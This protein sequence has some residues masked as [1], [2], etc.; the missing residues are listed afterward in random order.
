M[1]LVEYGVTEAD[2][3][4]I[5]RQ[6]DILAPTYTTGTRDG[7][8]FC[9]NQGVDALRRLRRD[10][11]ELWAEL[12]QL[13]ET[14]LT[15]EREGCTGMRFKMS[16]QSLHDYDQRF[17][18]ERAGLVLPSDSWDWSYIDEAEAERRRRRALIKQWAKR[19]G[20]SAA[21][22]LKGKKPGPR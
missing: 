8:F 19:R 10:Y 20:P 21:S 16:G 13:D 5:C 9:H 14:A 15:Y 7:C 1:P 3:L 18:A 22:C 12:M 17:E 11:P 4:E 2:A 6:L